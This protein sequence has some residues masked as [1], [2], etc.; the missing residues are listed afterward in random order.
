MRQG[1]VS[2]QN[3]VEYNDEFSEF[4]SRQTEIHNTVRLNFDTRQIRQEF[5]SRRPLSGV[6]SASSGDVQIRDQRLQGEVYEHKDDV[7]PSTIRMVN[8]EPRSQKNDYQRSDLVQLLFGEDPELT[9][10]PSF[11]NLDRATQ[12]EKT[13]QVI[14]VSQSDNFIQ[15]NQASNS[16]KKPPGARLRYEEDS[17]VKMT[18]RVP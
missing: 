8:L 4:V 1:Y 9:Q 7:E 11:I 3:L 6:K 13:K 15:G 10:H 12:Q 17:D 18:A 2:R 16:K 5:E 14:Q